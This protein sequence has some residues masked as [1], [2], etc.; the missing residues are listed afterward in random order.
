MI[1]PFL[2]PPRHNRIMTRECSAASTG[3]RAV[4]TSTHTRAAAAKNTRVPAGCK[5]SLET[6]NRLE[7]DEGLSTGATT[8]RPRQPAPGRPSGQL[9]FRLGAGWTTV[10]LEQ[11]RSGAEPQIKED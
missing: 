4:A 3:Y 11:V 8:G 6:S 9:T 10:S 7:R 1:D 2:A 5:R